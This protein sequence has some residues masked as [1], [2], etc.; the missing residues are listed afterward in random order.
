MHKLSGQFGV[1]EHLLMAVLIMMV[2]VAGLFF[3][4]SFQQARSKGLAFQ[5][6]I[7][8]ILLS[9]GALERLNSLTK[10]DLVFDDSKLA[11]FTGAY[12]KEGCGEIKKLA[13]VSCVTIEK[14]LIAE[15]KKDCD[16]VTFADRGRD[17]CNSWTLCQQVCAEIQKTGKSK[18]L[19]IP[20]NVYRS[21]EKRVDL[22]VM[23]V[24]IPT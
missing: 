8:K 9:S 23:T 24:R 6:D 7:H 1:M 16:P 22:A 12:E 18:G 4:F 13:G 17:E 20:V 2:V 21:L 15:D 5:D 11:A 19:S 14:V 10:E 3:F